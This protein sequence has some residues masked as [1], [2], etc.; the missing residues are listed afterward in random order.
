METKVP[1]FK[2]GDRVKLRSGGPA[3][4]VT[5]TSE[6]RS[7]SVFCRWFDNGILHSDS[8]EPETLVHDPDLPYGIS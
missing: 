5:S 8:F 2:V 6:S 3:M 7:R 1:E 4:T